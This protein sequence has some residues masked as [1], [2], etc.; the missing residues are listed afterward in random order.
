MSLSI[1]IPLLRCKFHVSDVPVARKKQLCT[2]VYISLWG[3]PTSNIILHTSVLISGVPFFLIVRM[4]FQLPF[5]EELL[6]AEEKDV[7]VLHL[8]TLGWKLL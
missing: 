5:L 8:S 1:H 7:L 3:L 6:R 2:E 4:Y